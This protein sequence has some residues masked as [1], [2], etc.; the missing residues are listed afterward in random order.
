MNFLLD[1]VERFHRICCR[2]ALLYVCAQPAAP[3]KPPHKTFT[4][5]T[6]NFHLFRA[7]RPL[8][9]FTVFGGTNEIIQLLN[10]SWKQSEERKGKLGLWKQGSN[11]QNSAVYTQHTQRRESEAC[12][13][14]RKTRGRVS[15]TRMNENLSFTIHNCINHMCR[16]G[17]RLHIFC[18]PSHKRIF[19]LSVQPMK[20]SRFPC[21]LTLIQ[22]APVGE[23]VL[24]CNMEL[25][26][27]SVD[28]ELLIFFPHVVCRSGCRLS[29][30]KKRDFF[31]LH[32]LL[33]RARFEFDM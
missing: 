28:V 19:P 14:S 31:P 30:G 15:G 20:T 25:E 16:V 18:V 12:Y 23:S 22:P 4:P 32:Q 10:V 7:L 3:I 13:F 5:K 2:A 26:N 9:Q 11:M 29:E 17:R 8:A 24:V 1:S 33:Q 21:T 6:T 27:L